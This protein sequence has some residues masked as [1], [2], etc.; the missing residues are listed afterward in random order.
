MSQ[1]GNPRR[2]SLGTDPNRLAM[3]LSVLHRHGGCQLADQDV[4]V[5]VVGGVKVEETASDVPLILA[6]LSSYHSR[7]IDRTTIAFGEVGR[8]ETETLRRHI[9]QAFDP[10]KQ[11]EDM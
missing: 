4:F 8:K 5:N 7:P 10:K 3:L 2:L 6:L 1:L 11:T 9:Q